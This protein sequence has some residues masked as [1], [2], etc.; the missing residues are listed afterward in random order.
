MRRCPPPRKVRKIFWRDTLLKMGFQTY[1][2]CSKVPS[3]CRKCRF[4]DPNF[5]MGFQ[6]YIFW[7]EVPSKCRKCRFRDPNFKKF[8]GRLAPRLSYNCVV[9]M[10][11]PSLKSW[12]RHWLW[13]INI[14]KLI[15]LWI[16]F[17][18]TNLTPQTTAMPVTV[19]KKIDQRSWNS[20]AR[21]TVD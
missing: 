1:I 16:F 15:F 18:K 8:Q 4:R 14:L 17:R 20:R 11:S 19:S 12:L 13:Q 9:T 2:F 6:T 21:V 7:S 5:K 3:K 10:A